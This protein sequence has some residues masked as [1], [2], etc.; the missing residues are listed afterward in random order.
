MS[1][2]FVNVSVIFVNVSA[3]FVNVSEI[4]VNVSEFFVNV[5]VIF[6]KELP[7][8][9]VYFTAAKMGCMLVCS[10]YQCSNKQTSLFY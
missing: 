7:A 3:I 2:I 10:R 5:S 1:V 9:P 4:F 8:H 6:V